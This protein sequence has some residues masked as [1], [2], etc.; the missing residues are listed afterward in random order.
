MSA[1]A[2]DARSSKAARTASWRF[3]IEDEGGVE[4][5][6]AQI[7]G[8][9][10]A[11]DLVTLSGDLG[12]GKTTLARALIRKLCN[13]PQLEAPSPT[14]TLMQMYEGARFPV[15]HAD[16]Y[17][18]QSADELAELGWDEAAE[19][20][21]VLVEWADRMGNAIAAD[22]LDVAMRLDPRRGEGWREITLTGHGAFAER[23]DRARAISQ[24]LETS[25]WSEAER[26]FMLG[27]ASVRA[28]ERL[29]KP[30]GETAIL[31]I[32][33]PRPD[34]PPVRYGKPYSAIARLAE[35]IDPFI[36]M[37]QALRA[38]G[39]SAP[40]ILASDLDAGLAIIEDLGGEGV[41]ADGAPIAERYREATTILAFLPSTDTPR[42]IPAPRGDSYSIPPYDLDALLI[43]VELLVEWYAPHVCGAK[44]SSAAKAIFLSL[45]RSTLSEIAN[46][47]S[48]WVLRDYHSPNLIWLAQRQ[49]LARVGVI[50]FQDCVLGHPAYDVV[51]LLQDARVS[52]PDDL[53]LRLLSHYALTRGQ[54]D[55]DFVMSDFAAA[56][57]MLGA[58][59][60]TKILGIFARLDRRD[61]KPAYLA[62]IP[63]VEGYLAKNLEHPALAAIKGWYKTHLPRVVAA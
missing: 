8:L 40:E 51:S 44:L 19:G 27:D 48:A 1:E 11:G 62:H 33:P 53:E 35:N 31:M 46:A 17:R 34:G 30:G 2:S 14:F 18:V 57:A 12:A 38:K 10:Q 59:R 16:L 49:G 45:W 43:E 61:G 47:R 6:A 54:A 29:R 15:V 20:A 56:Y 58:Q 13:D 36:A 9:A 42:T 32:S 26:T 3:E 25:G 60:A 24:L 23:V 63:R 5:L 52:V 39:L 50:D 22:R 4:A 55:A 28:Y 37:S 21:L 7:A 41:L